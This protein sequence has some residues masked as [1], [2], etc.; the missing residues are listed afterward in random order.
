MIHRTQ[1]HA[2]IYQPSGRLASC[3][4]SDIDTV[5]NS[6]LPAS[7]ETRPHRPPTPRYPPDS[8]EIYEAHPSPLFFPQE[9]SDTSYPHHDITYDHAAATPFVRPLRT[10]FTLAQPGGMETNIRS[11]STHID[12]AHTSSSEPPRPALAPPLPPTRHSPVWGDG[13]PIAPDQN[14]APVPWQQFLWGPSAEGEPD[15]EL[16]PWG[17]RRPASHSSSDSSVEQ[18]YHL[19]SYAQ[20]SPPSSFRGGTTVNAI[21]SVRDPANPRTPLSTRS[22]LLGLDSYSDVTV[23]HRDIVYNVRAIHERLSTGGGVTQ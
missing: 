22:I 15:T 6:F 11:S 20:A 21:A 1:D 5:R 3:L 8:P 7:P 17:R 2:I 16:P 19:Q 9:S 10:P 18:D 14:L 13:S 12:D 23:A 4:P